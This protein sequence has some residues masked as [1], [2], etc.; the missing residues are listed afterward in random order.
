[1]SIP[2][3]DPSPTRRINMLPP[4]MHDIKTFIFHQLGKRATE[5]DN[6]PLRMRRDIEAHLTNIDLESDL[7]DKM[8]KTMNTCIVGQQTGAWI[9]HI[10]HKWHD[11][12]HQHVPGKLTSFSETT[13][14]P[15]G[16][17]YIIQYSGITVPKDT[18]Y[19]TRQA[20]TL[21]RSLQPDI[22]PASETAALI[23]AMQPFDILKSVLT[24][25]GWQLA[26]F[27]KKVSD[28]PQ[29]A[30]LGTDCKHAPTTCTCF[31]TQNA[32]KCSITRVTCT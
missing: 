24:S 19:D 11:N 18:Q 7:L 15:P 2:E 12:L 3:D 6:L 4:E 28:T 22:I 21:G 32:L 31:L 14:D 26:K 9:G 30:L 1:L 10:V 20:R 17:C 27:L 5:M 29:E 25:N 16:G 23:W 8:S 13:T